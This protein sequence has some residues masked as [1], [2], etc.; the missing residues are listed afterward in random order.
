MKNKER[1]KLQTDYGKKN[2]QFF[3]NLLKNRFNP[4]FDKSYIRE[5]KRLSQGFNLRLTR[6]EKLLFC[7]K[8]SIFWDVNT[9]EIRMNS[10]DRCKEYICKN[11][12][13]VRRFAYK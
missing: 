13:F 12:G 2:I 5:I 4:E 11:C 6:E 7:N 1:K 9:R 3:L 10:K 8:C